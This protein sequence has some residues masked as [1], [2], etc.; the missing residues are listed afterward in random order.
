MWTL[1]GSMMTMRAHHTATLLPNG[2][3]LV[4]GGMG[5]AVLSS[6]EL[7]EPATE[8]WTPT[9]SMTVARTGHTATLLPNGKV[10]VTGGFGALASAELYDPATGMWTPTGSMATGR[11]GH[12]ATL[13]TE[14]KVLVA[15]GEDI[16][17]QAFSSAELYEPG[18][19]LWSTTGSMTSARSN[20]TA[21]LLPNGAVLVAAGY[22]NSYYSALSTAELYDPSR[23]LWA[24]TGSLAAAR[25]AHTATMLPDGEVLI[26]AG[27]AP[28]SAERYD[29]SSGTWATTGS[30]TNG[31]LYHTA[32][33]LPSGYVL[34]AGGGTSSAELYGLLPVA[35]LAISK[36]DRQTTASPGQTVTY[37]IT[38][39]NAGPTAANGATVTDTV[40]AA[41]MGATWTCVAAGGATCTAGP[42][43][44]NINDTVDLPAGGT[45]TYTLTGQVAVNAQSLSN[46]ATI[47][48]PPHMFD[49]NT[50]DNS[51]TDTDLLVCNAEKV[52]VPD[53]RLTTG[54]IGAGVTEWFAAD[55]KIGD[56]YSLEFKNTQ[57]DS[58]ASSVAP[59]VLTVYRGD[60]GCSGNSTLSATD[61]TAADPSDG[62]ASVRVS[63]TASGASTF[64]RARLVNGPAGPIQYSVGWSDT[65][66]FSPAWSTNASF[67]TYYAVANTTG[68]SLSG[69]L[70]L[71]DSSGSILGS[72]Y[73]TIPAGQKVSTN[74]VA[75]GIT[76]NRKGFA[77]FTHDGPPGAAV[78]EAAIANF[79][80]NPAYVQHVKFEAVR[81]AR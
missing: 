20:H 46:T 62:P 9:G 25:F 42:V 34:A 67:D 32:T 50:A 31:R 33:L 63:F 73:L 45:V 58:P 21:T 75:L 74:T 69:V 8:T 11:T 47:T 64:F 16:F 71:F 66:M 5:G 7:Y 3:I 72:S 29:P 36:S 26:A 14:G 30:L 10:L 40:P 18:T 22:Q 13:L 2:K 61:T 52:L 24:T 28:S 27:S 4:T 37:T 76:R 80:S 6:S 44:G 78:T 79:S 68:S 23:G 49:P 70:I 39:S 43:S 48:L 38:G 56:S 12:T 77:R 41:F 19:G 65:T 57:L 55:L 81:E 54:T 17:Q 59:G 53:G 1:T 15:G 60:D 51:A 35:D